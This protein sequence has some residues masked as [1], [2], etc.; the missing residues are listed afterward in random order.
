MSVVRRDPERP[1]DPAFDPD[2]EEL[3]LRAQ[4][5]DL[6]A[7]NELVARHERSVFNVCL[8]LL[9]DFAAAEDAS[10]DT[11]V[12]AWTNAHTF[13]GGEVRPWLL[14]IAT[15]RCYDI[16]R[17]KG[18]RPAGSL[19]AEPFEIEPIW[20]TQS[21]DEAPDA[22]ALRGELSIHL[23]RALQALPEDQR[24]AVIL[25]DVQGLSYEEVAAATGAALGTVKSRL[26]RARARL[27]QALVDDPETAEL[28][29]RYGR[30]TGEGDGGQ[31]KRAPSDTDR[32]GMDSDDA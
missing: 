22:R 1:F 5:G 26:S 30:I 27:R 3:M 24:V 4:R 9:R 31:A 7:Y 23:E 21:G 18:R 8:R 16:L 13:R 12:R 14:R 17:A 32:T 25:S 29:E 10:Q 15:N 2:D 20:S 28:F 6:E 19:D 11:F